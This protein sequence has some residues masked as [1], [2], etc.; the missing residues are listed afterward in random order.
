MNSSPPHILDDYH[1]AIFMHNAAGIL[2]VDRVRNIVDLNPA[3]SAMLH[4]SPDELIGESVIKIHFSSKTYQQFQSSFDKAFNSTGTVQT[5]YQFRRKD[6]STLWA[7]ILGARINLSNGDPGVLWSMVDTTDLHDMQEQLAYQAY[8]DALTGLPNRRALDEQLGHM[9]QVAR[10]NHTP[11]LVGLIDLD[12]FKPINDTHGHDAGDEV[13]RVVAKRLRSTLSGEDF[14]AR[15]GGDEFVLVLHNLG[16][17]ETIDQVFTRIHHVLQAPIRLHD[18]TMV[19]VGLSAGTAQFPDDESAI[20]DI[21]LRYAD[22]A[23]YASKMLKQERAHAWARYGMKVRFKQNAFQHQLETYGPRVWYQPV[24][25]IQQGIVVGFEALARFTDENGNIVE[26][27]T[28]LP[29]LS[30][31]DLTTL[32]TKVFAQVLHDLP[33]LGHAS[34]SAPWVSINLPPQAVNAALVATLKAIL[35]QSGAS[36]ERIT[37]E[38]MEGSNFDE[39]MLAINHL[40]ELKTIGI[41]LA[42]DDV[43]VGYASLQRIR[44]L[45]IDKIKLDQTFVR[46][47]QQHPKDMHFVHSI[48]ELAHG[49]NLELIVEGIESPAI[50]NAMHVLGIQ[51]V[52]GFYLYQPLPPERIAS[53]VHAQPID[54]AAM[55]HPCLLGIYTAQVTMHQNLIKTIQIN[56]KLVSPDYL[57]NTECCPIHNMLLNL[58]MGCDSALMSAHHHLHAALRDAVTTI[59]PTNWQQVMSAQ[60]QIENILLTL[61]AAEARG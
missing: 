17:Q 45:P 49:L 10:S 37:F 34:G 55:H 57:V 2:I 9:M 14:I 23:L 59:A 32:T 39:Q 43:G 42:I 18:S 21:L 33:S 27:K 4:F 19:Q 35:L 31:T 15:L 46:S 44:E 28:F 8:H 24:V 38:I 16:T 13:L 48:Q 50:L 30:N 40:I 29:Q 3:L 25:D 51:F 47:L 41:K 7:K 58:K 56:P 5:E 12:N 20:P 6:G 61:I 1:K 26:P 54:T 36:G 53:Q 22:Q 52:Q 11:L 60:K